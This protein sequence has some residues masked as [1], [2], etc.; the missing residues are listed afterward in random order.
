MYMPWMSREGLLLLQLSLLQLCT[1]YHQLT[2]SMHPHQPMLIRT[3]VTLTCNHPMPHMLCSLGISLAWPLAIRMPMDL[4]TCMVCC[5]FPM[6]Q[7]LVC[8]AMHFV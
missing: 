4:D 7:P 1:P 2:N 5:C 3:Q 6:V 8:K